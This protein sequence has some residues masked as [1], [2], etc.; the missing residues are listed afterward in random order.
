MY[1]TFNF[2]LYQSPHFEI[3]HYFDDPRLVNSLAKE[4]EKWYSYHQ[5]VLNDTFEVRNPIIFYKNHAD[6]QQ[7]TAISSQIDVGTGGV[8]EGLK[9]RVVLPLTFTQQQT[10][11]VLGHELVH[12][13][14]YHI[15]THGEQLNIGAVQNVPLWM[16]EGM[17]EY[18]SIGSVS[19]LST[20]WMRDA[21]L[22]HRFP[23]LETLTVDYSFSPYRFGHAFWAYIA[24]EYGEQYI[25]RLFR[26]TAIY[27]FERASVD[28]LGLSTDSLSKAWYGALKAHLIDKA[29]S[30]GF[31]LI[32][33]RLV[34]EKNGGK[35]N[36]SPSISPDGKNI[37]FLSERDVFSLDLFLADAT[38]G[39]VLKKIYTATRYDE[40]DALNLIEASGTWSPDSRQFAYVAYI[41]GTT[42]LVVYSLNKNELVNTIQIPEV[43]A[44][45]YPAWS[46]DGKSIAFAGLK[47]GVSDLY[48]FHLQSKEVTNVTQSDYS[49]IQPAWSSGGDSI[50]FTTDEPAEPQTQLNFP[51]TNIAIYSISSNKGNVLTTFN[52]AKNMNPISIGENVLFLSDCDGRR[53]LY[54]LNLTTQA[55]R[56]L[57]DYPTGIT[58][59][60]EYAPALTFAGST[61][62]Y[63]MLWD[64]KF[65]IIK[66]T[67][68]R[69]FE[70]STPIN[71]PKVDI[72]A[73]RLMPYTHN[74]SIVESNLFFQVQPFNLDKMSFADSKIKPKFKLDYIG[75][76]SAGVMAGRFGTGMAGSIEAM[77]SDI[78]GNNAI[79]SGMSING[80]IYDFGG[81]I[82]Y[83]NQ[84]KRIKMGAS[85]SHI[86]YRTSSALYTYDTLSNGNVNRN[87]EYLQRRTF[88]DKV[89]V[90]GFYPFN[91]IRRVELGL[92][93]AYYNYRDEIVDEFYS[94]DQFFSRNKRRI[95]SPSG[96]DVTYLDA[97]YVIDNSKAGLASPVEGRRFRVQIEQYV[98][99]LSMTTFL[100]DYRKYFF[101]NPTSFALRLYHYGRYGNGSSNNRLIN[102]F[103]G[104]PWFVRGYEAGSFYGDESVDPNTISLNQLVG[105]R[106]I[107]SNLEWRIPFTGPDKIAF[108]RSRTLFSEVAFFFDGALVW[109]SK[110]HP[111][112]SLSTRSANQRIPFFSTGVAYRVNLFGIM[113]IEPFAAIPIHQRQFKAVQLGLNL[114]AGW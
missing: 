87:I 68:P 36:L 14:Q 20:L 4:S 103:A 105:S 89:S 18:L 27:G 79:Y 100:I 34:S 93:Y 59:I 39:E 113:I 33:E 58:G 112:W 75:N 46:P 104:Y 84:K 66:T 95:P 1:R 25:S 57:T 108:I 2:Q 76:M 81:Q 5:Q 52:G 35:Y 31:S 94:Y 97:A 32:G 63:N 44:M 88:E 54:A 16:I 83:L 9:R 24:N 62:C 12:A 82:A 111:I 26:A 43:D 72:E 55:I 13:F 73:S 110:L 47:D 106:M 8:T 69:L 3:Y 114:F 71:S 22:Q 49:C 85:L 6:F 65:T 61:I 102:L 53:N 67:L 74:G 98:Q 56:Q 37:V 29:N 28:L 30:H 38:T 19:S 70:M 91:R 21:I 77:F 90:F 92:S 45:S 40:I 60:T 107:V 11:H 7:T 15:I 109:D 23:S 80:E 96:F 17:A 41:K 51:F 50:V 10:D 99:G 64:G 78:L 42:S 101:L 48:L 86:P